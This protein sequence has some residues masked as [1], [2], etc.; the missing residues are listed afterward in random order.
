MKYFTLEL[1]NRFRAADENVS[2]NAHDDWDEALKR[3]R[4]RETRI[5]A[6]LPEGVRRFIDDR[7]C[8]HDARLLNMGSQGDN[9]VMILEMEPPTRNLV[10]MMF[11]LDE[12]LQSADAS[13]MGKSDSEFVT[14]MYEE[15]DIDRRQR[16]CFS[17]LLSNGWLVQ[18]RLR[19]FQYFIMQQVNPN[20]NGH[21]LPLT[22]TPIPRSA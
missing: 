19:D 10:I 17:V 3:Y 21:A 18:L 16:P 15:W 4:R 22:L 2:A 8:L 1:L 20:K 11:T 12:K 14:W 7:V 6:A 5:K 9:F 13:L